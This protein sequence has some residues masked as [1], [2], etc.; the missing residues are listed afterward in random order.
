[1]QK[2]VILTCAL[3]GAANS[4]P[5]NR[6]VPVT[7]KQIA[8]DAH[9][10]ASA[11][12]AAV[13]VHVRNPD[14]GLESTDPNLFREVVDRIRDRGTDVIINLTTGIGV[15]VAFDR[16][17]P[18]RLD[19]KG[20]DFWP[21]ERRLQHIELVRPDVCSLDVPIMNFGEEPFLNLPEHVRVMARRMRELG[22]KPEIECFDLG[23]LWAV[24]RYIDEGL[25]E[26]PY[27]IQLC[28]GVRYGAP[29]T[30][31]ALMALVDSLP[32]DCNWGAFGIGDRQMPIV[33]QAVLLG[34]NVRVGLED[35]LYLAKNELATNPKL[36]ERA[37]GIIESLG[38]GAASAAAAR[39]RLGIG[40]T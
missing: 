16:N 3:T 7:P 8:D 39:R 4:V 18:S 2:E 30:P 28:T 6:N 35:N 12:A 34:G 33:A 22:V 29:A 40:P 38:A 9:D 21:P 36:V 23:D 37:V 20:T 24:Q 17:D 1:M 10:A 26:P 32:K 11:G 31:R 27:L 14:T 13:H 19:P 5:K 25:F 15:T